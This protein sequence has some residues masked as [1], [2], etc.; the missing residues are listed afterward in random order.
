MFFLLAIFI[1]SSGIYGVHCG[2][3]GVSREGGA[4]VRCG[5]PGVS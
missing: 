5:Q 1:R 2:Q 3:P 4:S